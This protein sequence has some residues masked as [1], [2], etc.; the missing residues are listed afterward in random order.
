M[1]LHTTIWKH[2]KHVTCQAKGMQ[3]SSCHLCAHVKMK[4]MTRWHGNHKD[5][6]VMPIHGSLP[7]TA[8]NTDHADRDGSQS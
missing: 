5:K 8:A 7:A 4:D 6:T 2:L 3:V 1:D